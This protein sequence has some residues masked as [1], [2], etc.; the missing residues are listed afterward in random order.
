[1]HAC[2]IKSW[3]AFSY[4]DSFCSNIEST[5]VATYLPQLKPMLLGILNKHN[6]ISAWA[7]KN[8]TK[9]FF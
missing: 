1:M 9:K 8:Y 3:I 6:E 4:K 2:Y 5:L 7:I